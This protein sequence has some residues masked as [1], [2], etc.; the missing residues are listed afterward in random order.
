VTVCAT[1]NNCRIA[2]PAPYQTVAQGNCNGTLFNGDIVL[3]TTPGYWVAWSQDNQIRLEHFTTGASDQ[4][5]SNAG[6]SQHPHL[7][8]YGENNMLLTWG[9]GSAMAAQIRSAGNGAT[10]GSQFTINVNDHN[11]IALKSFPDGSVAYP[12]SGSSNT[13]V[14]IA[15]VHP[16][17]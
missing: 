4:T 9:S 13:K 15:R 16:C 1:D 6:A 10:V 5:I 8:S 14:K 7:A 17:N 2:Q 12:A 11:Y 3:S